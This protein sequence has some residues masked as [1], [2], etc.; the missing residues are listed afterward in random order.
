M[1]LM[2]HP[3]LP[4]PAAMSMQIPI[5]YTD[6]LLHTAINPSRD[7]VLRSGE[8]LI[9]V[10]ADDDAYELRKKGHRPW[11]KGGASRSKSE[12]VF[13]SSMLP[14]EQSYRKR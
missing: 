12:R 4:P 5:G 13:N 6:G 7:H 1:L 8:Q 10:A 11:K 3:T 14:P 9:V 2:C